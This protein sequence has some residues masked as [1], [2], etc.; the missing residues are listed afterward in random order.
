M[1]EFKPNEP[2]LETTICNL[3]KS[4]EKDVFYISL[5]PNEDLKSFAKSIELYNI[6]QFFKI[7]YQRRTIEYVCNGNVLHII[8]VKDHGDCRGMR[9]I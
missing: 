5:W 2:K 6:Q 7:N 3:I 8:S 4:K 9:Q 1:R